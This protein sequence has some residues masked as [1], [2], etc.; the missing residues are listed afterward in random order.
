MYNGERHLFMLQGTVVCGATRQKALLHPEGSDL[1]ACPQ[2]SLCNARSSVNTKPFGSYCG[3]GEMPVQNFWT[4]MKG[5]FVEN[6]KEKK[7]ERGHVTW[8]L[9]PRNGHNPLQQETYVQGWEVSHSLV[10]KTDS[11]W[12]LLHPTTVASRL[13]PDPSLWVGVFFAPSVLLSYHSS[14]Q[15]NLMYRWSNIFL[16]NKKL[17]TGSF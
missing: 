14:V 2:L 17:Q 7:K 11:D 10:R 1:T 8:C 15:T 16:F 5:T 13:Q 6:E 9:Y 4:I 12:S 3:T